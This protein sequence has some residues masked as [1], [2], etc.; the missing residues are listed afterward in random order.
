M[1]YESGDMPA[2]TKRKRIEEGEEEK[3]LKID[4][5]LIVMKGLLEQDKEDEAFRRFPKAYLQWG[6]KLKSTLKQ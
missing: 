1:L 6:E 3:K 4:E 5:L 2:D